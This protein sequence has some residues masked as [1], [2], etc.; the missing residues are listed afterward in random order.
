MPELF[1]LK[2]KAGEQATTEHEGVLPLNY[3]GTFSRGGIRTRI[4][5]VSGEVTVVFATGQNSLHSSNFLFP[6]S[7]LFLNLQYLVMAA[8][9]LTD[10]N[11]TPMMVRLHLLTECHIPN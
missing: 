6:F 7:N 5:R 1:K 8:L 2:L 3:T 4:A 11:A 9:L 10:C